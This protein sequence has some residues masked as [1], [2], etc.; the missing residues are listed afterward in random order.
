M[1][2]RR[3]LHMDGARPFPASII[4]LSPSDGSVKRALNELVGLIPVTGQARRRIVD[5][6]PNHA[7][8]VLW[9]EAGERRILLGADLEHSG[10]NAEGWLAVLANLQDKTRAGLFKVPHHGSPNADLKDVWSTM[11][12]DEP[13]AV[14]TPFRGGKGLPQQTDLDRLKSRTPHLYLTATGPGKA[15]RRDRAVERA[16]EGLAKKR[17]II[18]GQPGHVRVRWSMSNRSSQPQVELFNGAQLVSR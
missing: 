2:N 15:P 3:L 1:G 11:L 6:S 9:I 13:I 7:S 16:V 14:V 8:V 18:E 12:V 5:R 17:R 10:V 4:S